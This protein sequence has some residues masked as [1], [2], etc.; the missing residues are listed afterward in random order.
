[1]DIPYIPDGDPDEL[2][3]SIEEYRDA[4]G[5]LGEEEMDFDDP[6]FPW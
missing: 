6:T 5:D 4:V 1:M 3:D 2:Y